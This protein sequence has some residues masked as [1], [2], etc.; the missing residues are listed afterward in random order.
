MQRQLTYLPISAGWPPVTCRQGMQCRLAT[1]HCVAISLVHLR[2]CALTARKQHSSMLWQIRCPV[3][4]PFFCWTWHW[5]LMISRQVEVFEYRK[6]QGSTAYAAAENAIAESSFHGVDL[7]H[8]TYTSRGT[9]AINR[10]QFYQ[11]LANSM[12]SRLLYLKPNSPLYRPYRQFC[13]AR[14]QLLY[15]LSMKNSRWRS[16]VL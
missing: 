1:H 8:T 3:Q 7:V 6:S 12:Q 15:L 14:G 5:C 2:M 11:A 4:C 9:V 13:Q 16:C 10:D